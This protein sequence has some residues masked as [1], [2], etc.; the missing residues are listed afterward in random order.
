ML[1]T[2]SGLSV[3]PPSAG[4]ETGQS[5][6]RH[7]NDLLGVSEAGPDPDETPSSAMLL[8]HH[9]RR[10]SDA[11]AERCSPSA[12]RLRIPAVS[13]CRAPGCRRRGPRSATGSL[14][15]VGI[16]L[17]NL[18]LETRPAGGGVQ[19]LKR[20][21]ELLLGAPLPAMTAR[22]HQQQVDV[23]VSLLKSDIFPE[24]REGSGRS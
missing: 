8:F 23:A 24:R 6:F 10:Y 16:S 2:A 21:E 15:E 3:E 14:L 9:G 7:S 17:G 12:F 20:V 4:A 13:R 1:R 19:L 22:V 5:V 18:S 11:S